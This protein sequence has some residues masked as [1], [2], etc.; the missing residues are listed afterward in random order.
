MKQKLIGINMKKIL[1][2]F[3]ILIAYANIA[4][5]EINTE[6]IR[7]GADIYFKITEMLNLNFNQQRKAIGIKLEEMYRLAPLIGKIQENEELLQTDKL[8]SE[9][10]E[11]IKQTLTAQKQEASAKKR[12]YVSRYRGILNEEQ[13][14]L[15]DELIFDIANGYIKL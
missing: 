9:E 7:R 6:K 14:H 11:K 8:S 12:Y 15:L 1:I 3:L 5:A 10:K 2:L 4:Q 13:N